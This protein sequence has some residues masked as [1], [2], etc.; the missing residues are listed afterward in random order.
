[1]LPERVLPAVPG[2][3]LQDVRRSVLQRRRV[4][5]YQT[6]V[7][8]ML[9]G[10]RA[11]DPL[12]AGLLPRWC[13]TPAEV[14]GTG[15]ACCSRWSATFLLYLRVSGLFHMIVG[16]LHLFGFNLPE[17]HHCYFLAVELHRLLAADQHLLE[18]LHD[19]A[20]L[21]PGRT[22]A[23]KRLGTGDRARRR[24]PDGVPGHLVPARLPVVLDARH[25]ALA[26]NDTLFWGILA[27]LVVGNALFE[28]AYRTATDAGHEP[29][30]VE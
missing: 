6:G 9:R 10:R 2:R 4:T 18:R 23:L 28:S 25:V 19:E 24:R 5:I 15:A 8:W 29:H 16:M 26:W 7:E 22:S 1:M 3:G 12:P 21:L 17:T 30:V 20:L 27:A 14:D 13:S 11:S